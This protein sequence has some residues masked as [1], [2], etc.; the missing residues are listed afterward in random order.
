M[1]T[2]FYGSFNRR[3][4]D[5]I[6]FREPDILCGWI[7]STLL[8][9]KKIGQFYSFAFSLYFSSVLNHKQHFFGG[10]VIRL[11]TY[12]NAKIHCKINV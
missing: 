6:Y 8:V 5:F 3:C 10:I 1:K 12:G 4:Y 11:C 9:Y 2:K 7:S